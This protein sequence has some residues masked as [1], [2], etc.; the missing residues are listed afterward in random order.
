MADSAEPMLSSTGSGI[1]APP[2]ARHRARCS[3]AGHR[4]SAVRRRARADGAAYKF[5]RAG[6]VYR[7]DAQPEFLARSALRGSA[8]AACFVSRVQRAAPGAASRRAAAARWHSRAAT[9]CGRA[10]RATRAGRGRCPTRTAPARLP[11]PR[12]RRARAFLSRSL[13]TA[14]LAGSTRRSCSRLRRTTTR[15]AKAA[16]RR[17]EHAR[18]ASSAGL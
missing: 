3:S 9:W 8:K 5:A 2:S 11:A 4:H 1:A 6:T 16:K 7:Q 15:C 10:C 17:R 12:G 18:A 13:A 14:P